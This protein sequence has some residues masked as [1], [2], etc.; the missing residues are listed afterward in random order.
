M[1]PALPP[2]F[3]LIGSVG[4]AQA[5]S[6]IVKLNAASLGVQTASV[7]FEHRTAVDR[8]INMGLFVANY[9]IKD[10]Q[11]GTTSSTRQ[12]QGF[13]LTGEYRFYSGTDALRGVFLGPYLRFQHFNLK[14]TSIFNGN[15][16]QEDKATLTTFGGGVVLG[17]QGIIA[18]RLSIEPFL[19][20]GYAAGNVVNTHGNSSAFNFQNGLRGLELRPGLSIGFAFGKKSE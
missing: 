15:L 6:N 18:D 1:K 2:L 4:V 16:P 5:Q 12:F 9:N 13:G 3:L 20:V 10:E 11:S 19:G 14:E 8:S 17:W 7:F